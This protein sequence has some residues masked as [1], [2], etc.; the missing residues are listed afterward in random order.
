MRK[1]FIEVIKKLVSNIYVVLAVLILTATIALV[2]DYLSYMR[3]QKSLDLT[4]F[5]QTLHKKQTIAILPRRGRLCRGHT[6]PTALPAAQAL[7]I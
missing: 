4:E 6:H 3:S 1:D 2:S 5:N 7:Y